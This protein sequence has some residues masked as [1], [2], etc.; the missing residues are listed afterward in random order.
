METNLGQLSSSSSTE[1][2]DL[3]NHSFE[4]NYFL[5][6]DEEL[7]R[8]GNVLFM[9]RFFIGITLACVML[10][11]GFGN[12]LFI[13]ALVKNKKQCSITNI[14]IANLAVSDL[15]V[16]VVCCPFE[17]DYYVVREQSWAFGHVICSSVNYLRMVSL[18]VSTNALLA[19]AV[20]RYI[21]IVYPLEPRMMLR[22]ACGVLLTIWLTSL[23][24]AAPTAY[25]TT[26]TAFDATFDSG[27]KI[28]CGQIWPAN[29]ALFYKSYSI[30][31]LSIEFLIPVI[32]MSL[33]YIRICYELWFKDL[34]GVQTE[35]LRGRLHARRKAVLVLVAVLLAYI[36]C[37]SPFYGYA[38]IRDFYPALLL[39]ERHAIEVYYIVECIA[40]S[41]SIINTLFFMTVKDRKQIFL[42]VHY[43]GRK[44]SIERNTLQECKSYNP[45]TAV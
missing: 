2:V 15:L 19:I 37:W 12:L 21:V 28:F 22:T 5:Y 33:C 24:I 9:A 3:R 44:S 10:V 45:P 23:F 4:Y 29:M 43:G 32:I 38:I 8:N 1:T 7:E 16:A 31:L 35:Q 34:P 25:F 27:G 6:K 42:K 30:F 11:C 39:K 41:N 20:D 13:L 26:E 17:M 18:Y 36:F 40:I 14:L